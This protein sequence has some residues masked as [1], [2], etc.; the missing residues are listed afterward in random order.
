MHLGFEVLWE[1]RWALVWLLLERL[2]DG[3]LAPFSGQPAPF[4][5]SCGCEFVI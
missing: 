4:L 3:E 5:D 2:W 1:L